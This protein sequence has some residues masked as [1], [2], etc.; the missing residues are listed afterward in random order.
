M[1]SADLAA[2]PILSF[3]AIDSTNAEARRRAEAG[4]AGPLWI[5]ALEQTEGRGRRGRAWTT[6]R[7]NLAAT[8]LIATDKAPADAARIAFV[9]A[10]AVAD[11]ADAYVPSALVRVK[12]PNDVLLDGCKL[13]GT[14]IESGRMADGRVWL[15]LGM[16]VNLTHAP[17]SLERPATALADHLRV[18]VSGPPHP[19]EALA[20][21]AQALARRMALWEQ[22]G[23]EAVV[24]AW[25]ARAANLGRRCTAA[26][27]NE[28]IEGVAEALEPDGALRL[29]LDDGSLRR[30]TAGDVFLP[31]EAPAVAAAQAEAV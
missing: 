1:L 18:D 24:D 6:R 12:W 28:S 4:E 19:S 20:V 22:G 23:F 27:P 13:S 21:L 26:L 25:S 14:L 15:A 10:L 8:L 9:A 5:T 31:G 30:I 2:A 7:G 11:L 17:S 16:G 29:R 3:D